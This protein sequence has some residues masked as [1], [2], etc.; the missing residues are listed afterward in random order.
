M[1]FVTDSIWISTMLVERKFHILATI[2]VIIKI[3]LK[4]LFSPLISFLLFWRICGVLYTLDCFIG[5]HYFRFIIL[6]FRMEIEIL[7]VLPIFHILLLDQLLLEDP[8]DPA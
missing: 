4:K 7:P 8:L 2:I 3:Q 6:F 1:K 5:F